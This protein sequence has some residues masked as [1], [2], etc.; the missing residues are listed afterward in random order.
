MC[1]RT[2]KCFSKQVIFNL[3]NLLNSGYI[4][5]VNVGCEEK[6][7]KL[8]YLGREHTKILNSENY[9]DLCGL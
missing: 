3:K 2:R 4:F 8:K 1:W 9:K 6:K 5:Y 7:F